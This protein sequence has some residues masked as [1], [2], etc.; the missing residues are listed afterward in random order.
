[1]H[2][3]VTQ[4]GS[5]NR[6]PER[7]VKATLDVLEQTEL[8]ITADAGNFNS[9]QFQVCEDAGIPPLPRKIGL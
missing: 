6:Q 9:G 7:T 5:D 3:E 8:R 1:M 2:D 4:D